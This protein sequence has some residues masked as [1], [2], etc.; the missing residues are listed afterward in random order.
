MPK[1]RKYSTRANKNKQ[2]QESNNEYN[3]EQEGPRKIVKRKD[4]SQAKEPAKESDTISSQAKETAKKSDTSNQGSDSDQEEMEVVAESSQTTPLAEDNNRRIKE[5]ISKQLKTYGRQLKQTGD[6][7]LVPEINRENIWRSWLTMLA[8]EHGR[9]SSTTTAEEILEINV[10]P[11]KSK[12]S[13]KDILIKQG[14]QIQ[15]LYELHKET[16]E[17]VRW[18]QNQI[19]LQNEKKKIDPSEKVINLELENWLNQH[20]PDYLRK[21]GYREWTNT[22][23]GRHHSMLMQK[24]KN[25][26][27][28]HI[29]AVK[30]AIFKEFSLQSISGNK[31]KSL[32]NIISWKNLP[33]V[34][35]CYNKLYDNND[36]VIENITKLAFSAISDTNESF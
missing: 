15:A 3:N 19:K 13:C 20:H 18:I 23:S 30:N 10:Q 12:K 17:K 35:E 36:N 25:M 26:K 11:L 22:F 33:Q 16:L 28:I 27:K 6:E 29:A 1:K 8:V 2:S 31:Q 4:T 14:R 9:S 5:Y 32:Q 24:M 21:V 34:K 7:M